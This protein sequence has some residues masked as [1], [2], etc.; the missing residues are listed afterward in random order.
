M[1]LDDES[2]L[3]AYLDD[4][5]DAPRRVAVEAA[6]RSDP[7]L[8][9]R[10]GELAAA[11]DLVAGLARPAAPA[12][13][14]AAILS[15][16]PDRRPAPRLL[17]LP[18]Y[19]ALGAAAALAAGV[20]LAVL[21]K[22]RGQLALNTATAPAPRAHGEIASTPVPPARPESA[23]AIE[24]AKTP[25]AVASARRSIIGFRKD[26]QAS[27][28]PPAIR[29]LD[30]TEAIMPPIAGALGG[31]S[32]A[33]APAPAASEPKFPV[34]AEPSGVALSADGRGLGRDKD[35]DL[36]ARVE[37]AGAAANREAFA[38]LVDRP[39]V[40]R[41][42][43]TVDAID[44][45]TRKDVRDLL[46]G[47]EKMNP[48]WAEVSVS[49]QI[50]IDPSRPGKAIVYALTLGRADREALAGKLK[51]RYGPIREDQ[52]APAVAAELARVGRSGEILVHQSFARL[53]STPPQVP[54]GGILAKRENLDFSNAREALS[55][56]PPSM[57]P[58]QAGAAGIVSNDR[59]RR[60]VSNG[61][62][63][64][65]TARVEKNADVQGAAKPRNVARTQAE[66]L[67]IPPPP[68][69]AVVQQDTPQ[70]YAPAAPADPGD[71][72]GMITAPPE[73]PSTVLVWLTT[74][75]AE[76]KARR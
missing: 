28:P 17:R 14:P 1:N 7:H 70:L 18:Q 27:A 39:G 54:M 73:P 60:G 19:L 29:P 46:E 66:P 65:A 50:A 68:G 71:L 64:A 35:L 3:S 16:L 13:L 69:P 2:F 74:R 47:A 49:Q 33:A 4:E 48:R 44:D 31:A 37:P 56:K 32:P 41:I 43:V 53:R 6:L 36:K 30:E 12:G 20:F 24:T 11:R 59:E 52:P 10:L 63:A 42:T 67:A 38:E 40:H 72:V 5:L 58:S 26:V 15:R 22:P 57:E 62:A 8:T 21:M 55:F 61:Q 23:R 75:G 51:D 34:P 25:E 45:K 76:A 9:R